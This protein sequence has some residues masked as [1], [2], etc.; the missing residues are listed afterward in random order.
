[1]TATA[2][3]SFPLALADIRHATKTLRLIADEVVR[4][5]IAGELGLE[6]LKCL[7]AELIVEP[8][9][10]GIDIRGRVRAVATRTCGVSLDAFDETV[11]EPLSVRVSPRGSPNAPLSAEGEF[12]LDPMADD[13]PEEARDGTVDLC[14]LVVEHLTL[15]LDPFPRKP[16]AVFEQPAARRLQ[17][18]FAALAKLRPAP[19]VE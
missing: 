13:P 16:G 17:S 15:A 14:A 3:W 2:A 7:D 6:A 19:E 5:R 11:D 8:W 9:L 10:D 4:A 1:M 18:P 12:A